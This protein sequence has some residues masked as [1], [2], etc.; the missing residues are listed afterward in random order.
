VLVMHCIAPQA[1]PFTYNSGAACLKPALRVL[2]VRKQFWNGVWFENKTLKDL[3]LCIQLG[4]WDGSDRRCPAQEAVRNDGFTI[5]AD[6]GVHNVGLDFCGCGRSGLKQVQLLRAQLFPA[7]CGNPRTAATFSLLRRFQLLSF[8][9]K[10]SIY[11][12]YQ[13]LARQTD[14]LGLKPPKVRTPYHPPQTL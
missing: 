7:T 4:H 11:H 3:G 14:N 10:C 6:D 1:T 12:F 9:A 5:I 8:E 2:I 13:S